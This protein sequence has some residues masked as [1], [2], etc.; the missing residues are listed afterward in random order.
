MRSFDH[1]TRQQLSHYFTRS[2]GEKPLHEIGKHLLGCE[3][4]RAELRPP[5]A[6]QFRNSLM[7]EAASE[8]KDYNE[9]QKLDQ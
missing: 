7:F 4:C 2:I 8:N 5:T 3:T 6:A 1:L 9:P